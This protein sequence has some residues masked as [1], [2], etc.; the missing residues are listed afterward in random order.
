MGL[1]IWDTA[2]Q[3]RYS[4]LTAVHFRDADA[5]ILCYGCDNIHTFINCE[6]RW[7]KQIEDYA[8]GDAIILIIGCK[9]DKDRNR[10]IS[11][12]EGENII[13]QGHWKKY[14]AWWAE[15][16]AKT[17]HNVNNIFTTASE[18][19]M[20]QRIARQNQACYRKQSRVS[21]HHDAS[22]TRTK[23]TG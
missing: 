15:C 14:N 5:I 10:Q 11:K 9:S 1:Q 6:R 20:Q 13:K 16:S 22:K 8:K 18:M 19:V 3:G 17:G 21:L 23:Q 7:R 4:P 2:G 12:S